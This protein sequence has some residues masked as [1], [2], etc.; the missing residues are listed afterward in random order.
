MPAPEIKVNLVQVPVTALFPNK[1]NPNR[2]SDFIFNM[3]LNSISSHGF[4]D[5]IL[6][7]RHPELAS[8]WEIIDGEHRWRA[9]MQ[10]GMDTVPVVDMGIMD[11]T[12]AKKL[13][14]ITNELKGKADPVAMSHLLHDLKN[15][16]GIEDI[17]SSLPFTQT[18]VKTL[19]ADVDI[20]WDKPDVQEAG[21]NPPEEQEQGDWHIIS[22]KLPKHVAAAFKEQLY[23]VKSILSPDEE[24]GKASPIGAVKAIAA[25]LADVADDQFLGK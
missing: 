22:L 11:D 4:L 15:Q 1:W 9:A 24:P 3:E 18:E 10:L 21:N 13:T 25:V 20:E 17:L 7:R 12:T 19:L 8:T 6:A 2:Q 14:I 16:V 5:P 23:R